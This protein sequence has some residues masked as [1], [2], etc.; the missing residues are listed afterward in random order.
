M[1]T[2]FV[3]LALRPSRPRSRSRWV[4]RP[5]N[6][7][8]A[9]AARHRRDRRRRSA[10]SVSDHHRTRQEPRRDPRLQRVA[11]RRRGLAIKMP[12]GLAS[13]ARRGQLPL[14]SVTDDAGPDRRAGAVRIVPK[15][16]DDGSVGLIEIESR[17]RPAPRRPRSGRRTLVFSASPGS[18][19]TN[20]QRQTRERQDVQAGDD[21]DHAREVTP[22]EARRSN[23]AAA[24]S[25]LHDPRRE[26]PGRDRQPLEADRTSRGYERRR[27]DRPASRAPDRP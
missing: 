20:R 10:S 15:T 21:G 16:S 6:R 27:V 23:W 1:R 13:S 7:K 9:A 14:T 4:L 8:P 26:V 12:A 17:L 2:R 19:P 3:M 25:P 18:K 22:G 5:R 11:G 24:I